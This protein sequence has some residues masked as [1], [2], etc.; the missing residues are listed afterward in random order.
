MPRKGPAKR[1]PITPDPVYHNRLVTRFVNRIMLDGK[2]SIAETIF[3]RALEQVESKTGRKGIEVFE[4]AVKNVMP[5]VEVKPRRVGGATY[6]VPME[7][8]ADRKLSLALRWIVGASRKRSG[9]TMID[10]LSSELTDAANNTGAAVRQRDDKHKMADANK[11]FAH[12]R[13]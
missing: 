10:R 4:Q 5:Q 12:Y 8:R 11:A 3:Y 6:Q 13:F 9:K 2:K 1:R 7:I